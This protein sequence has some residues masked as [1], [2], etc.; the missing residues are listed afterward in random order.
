MDGLRFKV[1]YGLKQKSCLR[2]KM[3]GFDFV[4]DLKP[5]QMFHVY[6]EDKNNSLILE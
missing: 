4:G 6:M 1:V 5:F 3:D 2:F